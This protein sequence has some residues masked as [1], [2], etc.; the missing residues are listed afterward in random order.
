LCI[1]VRGID[2]EFKEDILSLRSMRDTRTGDDI[3]RECNS[4]LTDANLSYEKL[5]R[6]ATDDARA[7]IGNQKG[8][9]GRLISDLETRNLPEII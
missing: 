3:F 2:A 1:F 4:A 9:Q 6:V 8:L 5:V 7:M